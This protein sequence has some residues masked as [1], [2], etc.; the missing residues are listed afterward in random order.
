MR[1][2][3]GLCHVEA[4]RYASVAQHAILASSILAAEA[5]HL[6]EDTTPWG[7]SVSGQP[8]PTRCKGR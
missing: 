3:N 5:T 6:S 8:T 2:F 7:V 1:E 4:C